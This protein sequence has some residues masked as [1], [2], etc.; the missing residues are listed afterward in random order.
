MV[1][2]F[3][4]ANRIMRCPDMDGKTFLQLAAERNS[5]VVYTDLLVMVPSHALQ[6]LSHITEPHHRLQR[7]GELWFPLV[8]SRGNCFLY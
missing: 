7:G 6:P 8:P 4:E 3:I 1:N 2:V 5:A